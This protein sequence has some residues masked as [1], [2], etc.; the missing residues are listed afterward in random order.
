[1]DGCDLSS[2]ICANL[3]GIDIV[4]SSAIRTTLQGMDLVSLEHITTSS[5]HHSLVWGF[6][7]P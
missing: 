2:A 3:H 5:N 1:M 4:S 7:A 6:H